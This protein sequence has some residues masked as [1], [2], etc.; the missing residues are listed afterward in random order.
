MRFRVLLFVCFA[1]I[2]LAGTA[3]AQTSLEGCSC[4]ASACGNGGIGGNQGD[5]FTGVPPADVAKYFGPNTGWTCVAPRLV[6][7]SGGPKGCFCADYC[8]N[9]G[10]GADPK[11]F[12]LGLSQETI[13][14]KYGGGKPGNRTG[15]LCG[16]YRGVWSSPK[17]N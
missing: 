14:S 15:W 10:I 11:T 4:T 9:G 1:A 6:R 7:G 12:D 2:V 17:G 8:G 13:D 3:G 5:I 16:N